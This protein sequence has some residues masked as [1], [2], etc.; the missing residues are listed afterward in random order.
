[1]VL[2]IVIMRLTG[3]ERPSASCAVLDQGVRH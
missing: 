1:M 3:A 2:Y